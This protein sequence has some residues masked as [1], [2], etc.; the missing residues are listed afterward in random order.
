MIKAIYWDTLTTYDSGD[1]QRSK[2]CLYAIWPSP[3]DADDC[4]IKAGFT[5]FTDTD[6]KWDA[7]WRAIISEVISYLSLNGKAVIR[8]PIVPVEKNRLIDRI[9]NNKPKFNDVILS[10]VEQIELTTLEDNFP[11][12]IVDFGN[13][14]S[15]SLVTGNGHPILWILV[16]PKTKLHPKEIVN[17]IGKERKTSQRQLDWSKL[18]PHNLSDLTK[19]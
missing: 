16:D 5:E 12:A 15:L 1:D 13:Q 9:L 4:F 2:H 3:I 7:D 11:L 18:V 19:E 6:D 14:Y 10:L 8:Q 17:Q